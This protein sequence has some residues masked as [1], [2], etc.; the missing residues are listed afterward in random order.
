MTKSVSQ[1]PLDS[2][3]LL[4][5]AFAAYFRSSQSPSPAQPANDSDIETVGDKSYVVLRNVRGIIAVYRILNSGA[6][7]RLRRWPKETRELLK[8]EET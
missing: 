5:R 1:Y 8:D 4:R 2:K 6:L 3:D 7:K